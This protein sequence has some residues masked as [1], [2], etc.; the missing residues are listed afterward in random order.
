MQHITSTPFCKPP[1]ILT[2]E[3]KIKRPVDGFA[4]GKVNEFRPVYRA[5]EPVK[6]APINSTRVVVTG[7]QPELTKLFADRYERA[8]RMTTARRARN[9]N[10]GA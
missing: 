2:S 8:V 9:S 3:V 4:L 1:T 5:L 7:L 6:A 10:K